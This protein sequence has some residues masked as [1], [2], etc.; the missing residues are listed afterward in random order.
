MQEEDK[1]E[2]ASGLILTPTPSQLCRRII[3]IVCQDHPTLEG[4]CSGPI[5][6][7][8]WKAQLPKAVRIAL[9]GRRQPKLRARTSR[10]RVK[11][12]RK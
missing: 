5:I 10:C 1:Y 6:Q 12:K 3:D 11:S 2:L 4:C 8:M 9:A 7:G